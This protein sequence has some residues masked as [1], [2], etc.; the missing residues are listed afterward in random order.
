MKTAE[1]RSIISS[2]ERMAL[3]A[4]AVVLTILL[5][6]GGMSIL[7]LRE[8][9]SDDRQVEHTHRVIEHL[10]T[11]LLAERD[12]ETGARLPRIYARATRRVKSIGRYPTRCLSRATPRF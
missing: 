4:F 6:I 2:I 12:M 7:F 3:F 11:C 9:I 8:T 1:R 10:Q 5:V